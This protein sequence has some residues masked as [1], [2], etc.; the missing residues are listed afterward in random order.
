[1]SQHDKKVVFRFLATFIDTI[2]CVVAV[3]TGGLSRHYTREAVQY[4]P[5]WFQNKSVTHDSGTIGFENT[6]F[7]LLV[8]AAVA[9]LVFEYVYL[10]S[11]SFLKNDKQM[12][13]WCL[14]KAA[15]YFVLWSTYLYPDHDVH[16]FLSAVL[17]IAIYIWHFVNE[18][19]PD[20]L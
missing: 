17:Y 3:M 10:F 4:G 11:K 9:F 18:C 8:I 7:W 2:L 13:I 5:E 20:E 16:V 19:R 14:V 15:G 12:W 6:G 1:M